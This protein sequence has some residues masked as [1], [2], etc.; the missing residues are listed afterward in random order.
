MK[1][2]TVICLTLWCCIVLLVGCSKEQPSGR[3]E[4]SPPA[5]SSPY[6][7]ESSSS[8]AAETSSEPASDPEVV[9]LGSANFDSEIAEGVVL[10]DFWATWCGPCRIQGPIVES[11]AGKFNGKAKIAKLDV[12]Q[13]R[14]IAQRFN[15][16][17]IPTLIVFR[18]GKPVKQ[19]IGVTEAEKLSSAIQAAIDAT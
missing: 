17:S 19:F 14:S 3:Q 12:D 1:Y 9:V 13:S 5:V 6:A 7:P 11:L 18:D 16:S 15:I 4:S 10:V 8:T 2:A